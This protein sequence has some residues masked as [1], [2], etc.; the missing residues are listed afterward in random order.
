MDF[1]EAKAK[2]SALRAALQADVDAICENA[3]YS[4]DG[5]VQ[6]IAA[7]I[8]AARAQ[9]VELRDEFVTTSEET[10]RKLARRLFGLPASAD[11]AT[12]LVYRDA[13]DRAAKITDPDEYG[14]LLQRALDQG[15][16]LMARAIAARAESAGVTDVAASYAAANGQTD[17][18]NELLNLP[19][20]RNFSAAAAMVFSVPM[21]AMPTE[22]A[23]IIR[24]AA[25]STLTA[26]DTAGNL[27]ALANTPPAQPTKPTGKTYRPGSV[28]TTF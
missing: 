12:V 20:G 7:A 21:P 16:D 8:V 15:D 10:R 11:A 22:I 24:A 26:D 6:L 9:A 18:H 23:D 13:A 3:S 19:S 5:Q 17:A 27:R 25:P 4:R 28:G 2:M 14:P 1:A